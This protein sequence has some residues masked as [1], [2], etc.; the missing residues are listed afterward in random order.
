[1]THSAGFHY[2]E[3]KARPPGE[4]GRSA[5]VKNVPT[6]QRSVCL[7]RVCQAFSRAVGMIFAIF[8]FEPDNVHGHRKDLHK[9]IDINLT[10]L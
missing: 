3:N 5:C 7:A 1:M 6:S 2:Q 9:F 4:Q 10:L 8:L